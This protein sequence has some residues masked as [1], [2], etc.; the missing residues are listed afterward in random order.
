MP[1]AVQLADCGP[2]QSDWWGIPFHLQRA[3]QT[4]RPRRALCRRSD[5]SDQHRNVHTFSA[6][7]AEL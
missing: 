2:Q 7:A 4:L 6:F 5:S 3:A 1:V